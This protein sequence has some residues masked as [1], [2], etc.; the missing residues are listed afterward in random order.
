MMWH[1]IFPNSTAILSE[2][3]DEVPSNQKLQNVMKRKEAL[4][5]SVTIIQN[6][7]CAPPTSSPKHQDI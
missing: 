4:N 5:K 1:S 3:L 2:N 7:M 6:D